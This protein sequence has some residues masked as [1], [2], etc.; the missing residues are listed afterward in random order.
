[1]AILKKH[2][3]P[4]TSVLMLILVILAG[5]ITSH[6]NSTTAKGDAAP[7]V[8]AVDIPPL[9]LSAVEYSQLRQLRQVL[10]IDK[11]TLAAIGCNGPAA[12]N[13]V[14]AL[15]SWYSANKVQIQQAQSAQAV[16]DANLRSLIVAAGK[17]QLTDAEKASMGALMAAVSAAAKQRQDQLNLAATVVGQTLTDSSKSLWNASRQNRNISGD[18]RFLSNATAGQLSALYAGLNSGADMSSVEANN[19]TADQRATL[20]A[21][22]ANRQANAAAVSSVIRTAIPTPMGLPGFNP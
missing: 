12:A 15:L 21:V 9:A 3:V 5:F 1:M 4:A 7:N 8:P 18:Y 17:R 22:R 2:W 6:V 16:A 10:C 19:L 14:A 20:S 11:D 13:T